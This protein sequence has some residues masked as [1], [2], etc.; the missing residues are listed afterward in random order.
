V[1]RPNLP[2]EFVIP[3][4]ATFLCNIPAGDVNVHCNNTDML[5]PTHGGRER[6]LADHLQMADQWYT[7]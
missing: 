1:E 6:A 3:F 7:S 2:R 5:G 4:L